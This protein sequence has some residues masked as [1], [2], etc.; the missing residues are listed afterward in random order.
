MST[1]YLSC[2]LYIGNFLHCGVDIRVAAALEWNAS[3]Q[4]Y[5]GVCDVL[6]LS[7]LISVLSNIYWNH[8][9]SH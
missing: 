4:Q 3:L 9:E 1:L 8:V 7:M 5:A 6:L 2:T